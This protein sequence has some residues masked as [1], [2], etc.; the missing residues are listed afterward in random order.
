MTENVLIVIPARLASTRLPDKPLAELCG[1]PMIV[2]VFRRAVEAGIGPVLVA[3]D[4]PEIAAA[5][6]QA[7]GEAVVT[8]PDL[9][10]G[11]DRIF[12][13]LQ[14]Y[15]PGRRYD[16][17]VN[18]QGDLPT[19]DPASV[20]ASLAPLANPAVD[21]ATLAARIARDEERMDP[22]VVKAVG[23]PIGP[24]R[25]RALYFTR[26]TAPWGE[27]DLFHHIGLYAYRRAALERFVAL[28]PSALER[29]EKL[30]QLRAL[31]AGMRIDVEIVDTVPLGVDTPADLERARKILDGSS[32]K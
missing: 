29:R 17:I 7:G 32:Q 1:A 24:S 30:E 14:S 10:S 9:P 3:A 21:I 20:R 12:A 5:I 16:V 8:D 2:Q 27:G 25:L 22:N 23:S 26:A 4:G 6:R 28:P 19:I 18:L 13:A 11:S 31:E 15:D